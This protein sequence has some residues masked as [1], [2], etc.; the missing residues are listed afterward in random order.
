MS[1][2]APIKRRRLKLKTSNDTVL[3]P[4]KEKVRARRW[5][6]TKH[7]KY[8]FR[9]LSLKEKILFLLLF[10]AAGFSFFF[11]AS[12][13]YSRLTTEVPAAGGVFIEGLVG[14]PRFI[15]PVYANTDA[16]RD[17][18]ELVFSGLMKYDK[19]MRLEPDLAADFP[20]IEDDGRTYIF[21]LKDGLLWQDGESLDADDVVFT[22]KTIQNPDFKSPY[23]A[24]WIGV[25]VE[26]LSPLSVKFTLQKPYSAF[27]ENCALKIIPSHIWEGISAESFAFQSYNLEEAVGSGMYRLSGVEKNQLQQ[28]NSVRLEANPRYYGQKP[29]IKK[30]D[31][32]FFR[33]EQELQRAAEDGAVSALGADNLKNTEGWKK[34]AVFLPRYFAVFLNPEKSEVLK[35]KNIRLALSYG[36][37][38]KELGKNTVDSPLM[39]DFYGFALPEKVY[40]YD[41]D[42]ANSILAQAGYLDTDSDGLREKPAP[43]DPSFRFKSRLATGS[44]GEEVK[45]L[46]KCLGFEETGFFGN[47]TK[48]AVIAFQEKYSD[49]ILKPAGLSSG[50]GIVGES[51]RNKLNEFCFSNPQTPAS[52]SLSLVTVDQPQMKQTAEILKRQW[53][54][55]G[56]QVQ[57]N[58][59]PIFQLEQEIIKPR[60]YEILLFGEVLGAVPDLFPFWHSSQKNDPGYNLS[61]YEN[62]AVDELLEDARKSSDESDRQDKFTLIQS[63]IVNDIPAIFLFSPE[64][65]YLVSEKIKGIEDKK[66]VNPS[67][68]FIGIENWHIKTKKVFK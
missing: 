53:E 10:L 59:Y 62:K 20:R 24:N 55:I 13:V 2:F 4:S 29:F 3:S 23:L 8:F 18:A 17:I 28:I 61:L 54:E 64:Y 34:T 22:I 27:L 40:A 21:T 12:G 30:I 38:K 15:N 42:Q 43:K 44:S 9:I 47:Q 51:T 49:E 5:P 60:N 66:A 31:F 67:K 1:S 50:T 26:K 41:P 37:N 56:I 11:L 32:I 57:I 14:Q 7:W 58:T 19:N 16:D 68:R 52:L 35:D 33:T 65:S 39:P 36:T 48:Q 45:R 63:A 25:G 46:Q 6:K